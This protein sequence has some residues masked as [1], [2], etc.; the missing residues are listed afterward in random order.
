MVKLK[1]L[2]RVINAC[3]FLAATGVAVSGVAFA[4]NPNL[5][6]ASN[7]E[8]LQVEVNS[9]ATAPFGIAGLGVAPLVM[10]TVGREHN[11]FTEAYSDYTDIDGDGKLD[12]MYDPSFHYFGLFDHRYC[13]NYSTDLSSLDNPPD[14]KLV[15]TD[16]HSYSK[17]SGFW[18]PVHLKKCG[19]KLS[20][21]DEKI[22]SCEVTKTLSMW[23]HSDSPSRKVFVCG[24]EAWS[25]NFLNY[26]TSSR[27]DVIRKVLYGGTRVYSSTKGADLKKGDAKTTKYNGSS[28][29]AHSRV[30]RDSHAWGKVLADKMYGGEVTVNDFTPLPST[31]SDENKAYFFLVASPDSSEENSDNDNNTNSF[32]WSSAYLKYGLVENAGM[33][34]V[35][36]NSSK[37]AFIWD[38]ASRQTKNQ[39]L[40]DAIGSD[41]QKRVDRT[42]KGEGSKPTGDDLFTGRVVTRNI[43]V[44]SC[45]EEFHD[46]DSC[47]NYGTEADP[48]WQPT[49]LLQQYGQGDSPRMKFGLVTGGWESNVK[50]GILRANIGDFNSEIHY[51]NENGHQA[52]DYDFTKIKCS[53]TGAKN[54]SLC[55]I[56]ASFDRMNISGKE[57]GGTSNPNSGGVYNKC[58]RNK[59]T[60]LPAMYNET[61][62]KCHDWGNPVG[63]ILYETAR[64]FGGRSMY[65]NN[66]SFEENQLKMGHVDAKDPYP[67]GSSTYC[68]KP[69][70]LLIADENISFDSDV[71]DTAAY[72]NDTSAVVK[73]TGAVSAEFGL[74]EGDYYMGG[75][76][77]VESGMYEFVPSRKKISNLNQVVGLAPAV[78]FS[79]G[80]YNV[81]GVASLY[82]R[83]KFR[84]SKGPNGSTEDLYMS[85]YVVAMKPNVPQINIPVTTSTGKTVTVEILPFAKTPTEDSTG[86]DLSFGD[87]DKPKS[88]GEF[89]AKELRVKQST[90][91]VADFYVERLGED[92]GVFRISY[93][94][95]EYGSDYDMDW[96]VGYKY[97]VLKGSEGTYIHVMLSHEDGDPYAPQHAGYVITGVENEGVFMDLG[98]IS[99]DSNSGCAYNLFEL[100]T[101]INDASI[102]SCKSNDWNRITADGSKGLTD[103]VKNGKDVKW[104]DVCLFPT[105]TYNE[106]NY[107]GFWKASEIDTYYNTFIKPHAKIYYG[108]RRD[109]YNMGYKQFARF[110]DY[111]YNGKVWNYRLHGDKYSSMGR[112]S[113]K[114]GITTSRVFKVDESKTGTGWLKTP[115]WF[116]AKYGI[117]VRDNTERTNPTVE[118]SNYYL[119]TNPV[120]LRNGIAEMLNKIDQSFKSGSSMITGGG[121]TDSGQAYVSSYDP[122]TWYGYFAKTNYVYN[123]EYDT[124]LYTDTV[125]DASKT[126]AAADPDERL[127]ITLDSFSSTE[128]PALKRL[129]AKEIPYDY[130]S[131]ESSEQSGYVSSSKSSGILH[132]AGYNVVRQLLNETALTNT[133]VENANY[134]VYADKLVRWILGDHK[135]EGLNTSDNYSKRFSNNENKPLRYR[136]ESISSQNIR[137]VLGDVINSDAVVFESNGGTFVAIGANDGML[138]IINDADGTPVV[139]YMPSA[140][141]KHMG[142]LV[143]ETYAT[144]HQSLVDSTPLLYETESDGDKKVYL[145][146][147]FG[148]GV[149]GAYMLNVTNIGNVVNKSASDKFTDLAT[150]T[151]PLLVWELTP[152]NS[153]FIGKQRLA[154]SKV[155]VPLSADSKKGNDYLVFGSGY[156]SVKTGLIFV[157][158]LCSLNFAPCIAK[159]I[160]VNA[161]DP[162]GY[163]R[164][165]ALAPIST[166][167][168]TERTDGGYL[169]DALYW[170]DLFGN[171]W[172]M[173]LRYFLDSNARK[174]LYYD[175]TKWGT[176]GSAPKVIFQA[177]DANGVAQPITTRIGMGYHPYGGI[178]LFIG[179]GALWT[180]ADQG[181]VSLKYN[182]TQ[183]VYVIRD[184]S[185]GATINASSRASDNLVRRCEDPSLAISSPASGCLLQFKYFSK[186][187]VGVNPSL[188]PTRSTPIY[189]WYL[190]LA[191]ANAT[192]YNDGARIYRNPLKVN[193]YNISIPVNIPSVNDTCKGG[194]FSYVIN[195]DWTLRNPDK[196][197]ER[198]QTYTGLLSE[199]RVKST[200]KG[201]DVIYNIDSSKKNP[202]TPDIA[203][204]HFP[205]PLVGSSSWLKMY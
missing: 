89:T 38:W 72:D 81:A 113:R 5:Q 128:T 85:T 77:N 2:S 88:N 50:G 108:N 43:A 22:K 83:N 172:K 115:L 159:S 104:G 20:T 203:A 70:S 177:K 33:P 75:V 14:S 12:I 135:Y 55:G 49:G 62:G 145:Y 176:E 90:N 92:E 156:D 153:E 39:D 202:G 119:V 54:G 155:E 154:P 142:K 140:M 48:V 133:E 204:F 16:G 114:N 131:W 181:T 44:V 157:K 201:V 136:S 151:D 6:G 109:L 28:L 186:E 71:H 100:D 45:T 144:D 125:W 112:V 11:L 67:D 168:T 64:Y 148:L 161:E 171:V 79:G 167:S 58:E 30:I 7:E 170:G 25:G 84:T 173:D 187:S 205:E 118:P 130:N 141:L 76:K 68:A 164:T 13:Y 110:E 4:A 32:R 165:N 65:A 59:N 129:Y 147:T 19:E 66:T 149:S 94:D 126:F 178:G 57:H 194:G 192:T 179:T 190:D 1:N 63:E 3:V 87:F 121:L 24:G 116:A 160:E 18:Y 196:V 139:S 180:T 74:V 99:A 183:S 93:E 184:M 60:I 111:S 91:Q 182:K 51:K 150:G 35:S 61:G 82:S 188:K 26:V 120:M 10:L 97:Q 198:S 163:G 166:V 8:I 21:D 78:A 95:F 52:G 96:V 105:Y 162:W 191:D 37:A 69:V 86:C 47:Y 197:M 34:G 102:D 132:Y 27:I 80:T 15:S 127:V 98:K 73:E 53:G 56:V 175:I 101:L 152:S 169:Y 185:P 106:S 199:G 143:K 9:P 107:T 200:E 17:F 41:Y 122:S 138:H 189:G 46:N 195:G 174:N 137:F 146:G 23:N 103:V 40:T 193:S 42:R 123:E 117:N 124:Y 134:L 29:L 31:G 36:N 158:P